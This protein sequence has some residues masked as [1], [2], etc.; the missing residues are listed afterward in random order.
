MW[1]IMWEIGK[2]YHILKLYIINREHYL[3]SSL[4]WVEVDR[5]DLLYVIALK[6]IFKK[7]IILNVI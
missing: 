1:K 7:I 6:N 4:H 5:D 3:Y 2:I